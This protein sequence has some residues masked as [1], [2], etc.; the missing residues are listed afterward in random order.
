MI[1]Q[2]GKTWHL[3]GKNLSYVV[4]V[5]S[6][7]NLLNFHIGGRIAN[8]DYSARE[9]LAIEPYAVLRN[10][11]SSRNLNTYPQEYPT[12]GHRDMRPPALEILN[13]YG[14]T[15]TELKF[16][17]AQIKKGEAHDI[18]GLPELYANGDADTL[19]LTL[20]DTAS[21]V[22]VILYYTV[23]DKYDII[24]R[25]SRI[26][27]IGANPLTIN[28]AYS[29]NIDLPLEDYELVHFSGDWGFERQL[30]RTKINIGE[31][32]EIADNTGRSTRW[33][34]PFV[35]VTRARVTEDSG[36]VLGLNLVYSG[37]HSTTAFAD[38]Y[39]HLR[40]MQGISPQD[41]AWT[42]KGG[43][44]F[45]SPQCI[46]SYSAEGY[47]KLSREMT[48]VIKDNLMRSKF[49]HEARPILINSWESTY[50]DF[51]EEKL[52]ALARRAADAGIELF[53]LD[54]GWFTNRND[55][56]GGLGD[57][58]VDSNKLPNGLGGLVEKIKALGLKFGLWFEPE[59]ISEKSKLFEQHPDWALRTP[60]LDPTLYRFQLTLDL[61]RE[62]V[63]EYLIEKVSAILKSADISYVKW[64]MNRMISDAPRRGYYYEYTL[65]LYK[66]VKTLTERFP[67]ILFEGC[68]SGGGRFDL[69]MLCYMPQIWASDN[70]D[71]VSRLKIQYAT[72]YGYPLSSMG[73]H[74]SAVPNHQTGRIT[75]LKTRGDIA[76]LGMFGFELDLG[77]MSDEELAIVKSQAAFAK[78]IQ[79]LVRE[80]E[81]Y[82]LRS[83]FEGNEFAMEVVS[84]DA[85]RVYVV[86]A[87]VLNPIMRKR[88]LHPALRLKGLDAG[89]TYE[90][91]A[92][93]KRYNGAL[94]M[95][96]GITIEYA[97]EDY[98]SVTLDLRKV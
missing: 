69:G 57:W 92:S 8:E 24:A 43:E 95:N 56:Y 49:T 30:A 32:L 74:V 20:E 6:E 84:A 68:A 88:N 3:M 78:E 37:P 5:D 81:V 90:E 94:L 83:P 18:P 39:G 60:Q 35:M 10:F 11:E 41:F 85:S 12:Y 80:G 40:V 73:A 44:S 58:E 23:F 66:L 96:R 77:K 9:D 53:V 52:L 31:K 93:G 17:N 19:E 13:S 82:R 75:P 14:N 97:Y 86:S 70:T 55:V 25:S 7:G 51:D 72:S 29:V 65:G 62:E 54:D 21:G 59:M 47:G 64:D 34:N 71:A 15:Q 26:T 42:L 61:S 87:Q 33:N 91:M 4:Y 38:M 50:L 22:R 28:S 79:E 45:D 98:T 36:E 48:H 63:R 2:N 27:N 67:D 89:A 76:S 46:I 1:V 16:A